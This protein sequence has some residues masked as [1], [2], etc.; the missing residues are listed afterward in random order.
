MADPVAEVKAIEK[1]VGKALDDPYNNCVKKYLK[2]LTE[3][4]KMRPT[5]KD[6][7]MSSAPPEEGEDGEAPAAPKATYDAHQ[8]QVEMEE[9]LGGKSSVEEVEAEIN[10]Y[11]DTARMY[12]KQHA[13]KIRQALEDKSMNKEREIATQKNKDMRLEIKGWAERAMNT[14][15]T[16]YDVQEMYRCAIAGKPVVESLNGAGKDAIWAEVFASQENQKAKA[17][18]ALAMMQSMNEQADECNVEMKKQTE[19]FK[20]NIKSA[21]D[22][23]EGLKDAMGK[24]GQLAGGNAK[25][26]IFCF[27]CCLSIVMVAGVVAILAGYW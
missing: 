11:L 16:A 15:N 9:A 14:I 10:K 22:V 18:E 1:E 5:R 8:C 4:T 27:L 12:E 6:P 26:P 23:T 20:E 17:Q 3:F 2:Y 25:D 19:K 21:E 13:L 7:P 24:L